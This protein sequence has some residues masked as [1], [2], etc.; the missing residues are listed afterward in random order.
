[1]S[2][3]MLWP[4]IVL[5]Y[6]GI[7]LY[8]ISPQNYVY[9]AL[10]VSSL[11]FGL[12]P[13]AA[14]PLRL[15][16]IHW[17]S[18]HNIAWVLF[19]LQLVILPL[20]AIYTGF[21]R[22]VLPVMPSTFAINIAILLSCVAYLGYAGG[23]QLSVRITAQTRVAT[24]PS[25]A[26]G[27]PEAL[28]AV[29]F[30]LGIIGSLLLFGGLR[31]Y[32]DYL[33]QP[34][35][36]LILSERLEG[37]MWGGLS[38]ILRPFLGWGILLAWAR[39]VDTSTAQGK[40]CGSS[41]IAISVTA[42]L[43][44]AVNA[45]YNRASLFGPIVA[46]AA[47]YTLR[48]RK[49]PAA[50][51]GLL[52]LVALIVS[53]YLGQY[54]MLSVGLGDVLETGGNELLQPNLSLIEQL[55]VYASAPQFPAFLLEQTG[56][57]EELYWGKTLLSSLLYPVPILGEPFRETSGVALYNRLIYGSID[58]IDQVVPFQAELF[59]NFHVLGVL[60]GYI[61]LGFA[62]TTM[63]RL[64][65]RSPTT[66]EAITWYFIGMWMLFAIPGSLAVVAQIA[67]F[68]LWP[69]YIYFGVTRLRKAH[70]S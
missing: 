11:V 60:L 27:V 21:T 40:P 10:I 46:L 42:L 29:Y 28:V 3:G 24:Q 70:H 62:V 2:G 35:Y 53:L 47:V 54:R 59:I 25:P 48:V 66:F 45:N 64:C 23:V 56:M 51:L 52:G 31:G 20:L 22:N 18:L 19:A 30:T 8:A 33:T 13:L 32:I 5:T 57:G 67:V 14:P 4:S 36:R 55:Q 6:I 43:L 41:V 16:R 17:L 7:I 61:T 44:L 63:H 34:S 65:L 50:F 68:F 58:H 15:N 1:M 9:P 37:T 39:W 69:I 26:E 49:I 12:V 38:T